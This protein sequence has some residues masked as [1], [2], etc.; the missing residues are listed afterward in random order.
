MGSGF[1]IQWMGVWYTKGWGK[2]TMGRWFN[3]P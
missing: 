3:I 1:K 2:I